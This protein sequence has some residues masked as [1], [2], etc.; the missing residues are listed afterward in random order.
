MLGFISPDRKQISLLPASVEEYLSEK[1]IACFVV[2]IV[3]QLDFTKIYKRYGTRGST[4]CD[5]KLLLAVLFY[6]YS[7]GT[8]SSRKLEAATYNSLPMRFICANLRPD[9]DTISNFR[10]NLPSTLTKKHKGSVGVC[11]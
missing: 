5:P 8:F 7:T 9:H 10:K 2:D 1:H 4:P 11:R 3:D 6:G